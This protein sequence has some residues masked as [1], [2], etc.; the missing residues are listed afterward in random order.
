MKKSSIRSLSVF[1]GHIDSAFRTEFEEKATRVAAT[2]F[3]DVGVEKPPTDGDACDS[4]NLRRFSRPLIS[5]ACLLG[6]PRLRLGLLKV[7]G[8]SRAAQ[9][10]HGGP[11]SSH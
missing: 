8:I 10:L 7:H 5:S 2:L 9:A 11:A 1:K 4:S 6:G 3:G